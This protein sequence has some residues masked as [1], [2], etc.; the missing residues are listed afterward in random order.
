MM[1][2]MFW[3][4]GLVFILLL[5]AVALAAVVLSERTARRTDDS[6]DLLRMRFASGEIDAE[7]YRKRLVE[8][9][10]TDRVTR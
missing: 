8:L 4:S 1:P 9:R 5:L 7:E 6:A 2:M 3:Y 10:S